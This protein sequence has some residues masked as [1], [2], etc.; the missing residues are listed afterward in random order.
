MIAF[1]ASSRSVQGAPFP[2]GSPNRIAKLLPVEK[3]LEPVRL[4]NQ[5]GVVVEQI[6]PMPAVLSNAI[7]EWPNRSLMKARTIGNFA[8][9]DMKLPIGGNVID[10]DFRVGRV[11]PA[12]R[13]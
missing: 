4:D 11:G 7:S 5:V 10:E 2:C 9:L 6:E 12:R 13:L 1:Y 3:W 8:D